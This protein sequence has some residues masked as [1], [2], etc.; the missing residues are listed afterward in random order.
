MLNERSQRVLCTVVQSY[1][2]KA[3]PVGSRVVTKK[4]PFNLSSA[5]IRNIM[6]DLEDMGFLRQPHTSAGRVPTDK[7]YRFF[8]DSMC[9]ESGG[10]GREFALAIRRKLDEIGRDLDCALG[11]VASVMSSLSNYLV[12]ASPAGSGSITLN[13]IQLYKYRRTQAV[14]MILTN[15]GIVK[16]RIM[17]T[18]F[19]LT[20]R[21]LN[22]VSEY[23]NSE[24]SGLTIEEIRIKVAIQMARDKAYC[25]TL[26]RRA[27]EICS[28]ALDFPSEGVHV[29]GLSEFLGLADFTDGIVG[30]AR[31]IEHKRLI[32]R[33]LERLSTSPANEQWQAA[34]AG[35][36]AGAGVR[37]LIGSENPMQEMQGLSI[38][39][40]PYRT[41]GR[42]L[43]SL[44]IIGPTRMDYSRAIPMVA[45]AAESISEMISE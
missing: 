41:G 25:D 8:V 11:E 22:R 5:S 16:T 24:F 23:L 18:D 44:G 13:R 26:I 37:V 20:Q 2:E 34:E 29:C 7:G 6:A 36:E 35:T 9:R 40:A 43:G 21:E 19:G 1:I 30:I 10:L 14:G 38:V 27:L 39:I 33:L 31:E 12:F 45:A 15:E 17:D 28:E 4:Y 3:A 42:M 32:F